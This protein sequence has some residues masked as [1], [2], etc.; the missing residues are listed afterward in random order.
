MTAIERAAPRDTSMGFSPL[1]GLMMATRG[2]D[3]DPGAITYLQRREG[4]SPE[5]T[6]RLLYY[7]CGLQGVAGESD[8]RRLLAREDA[9][10]RLAV[11]MYCHR[12]RKYLGAYLAVLGGADAI[13]FGGGVGENAPFVR[14]K[15]LA[16]MEWAGIALDAQANSAAVATEARISRPQSRTEIWV[17][18][19]DEAAI[20]AQEAVA[21]V[22]PHEAIHRKENKS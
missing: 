16:N 11:E 4:F 8:M 12:A 6:E 7:N 22:R 19:V 9:E 1:E 17:I 5:V 3:M 21:V 2:G 18:P 14:G 10:A 15:I 20:L 13:L